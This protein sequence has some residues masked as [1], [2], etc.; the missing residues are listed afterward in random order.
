MKRSRVYPDPFPVWKLKRVERST[1][2]IVDDKVQR[3]SEA[4]GGFPRAGRGE[5]GPF[6][7]KE[8]PRFVMK[9][10]LSVR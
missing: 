9:H 7:Q 4:H 2:Q 6:I 1:I 5:F 8:Y 10:P 3:K